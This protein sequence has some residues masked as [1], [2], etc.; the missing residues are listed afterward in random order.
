VRELELS[1][2]LRSAGY[3]TAAFVTTSLLARRLTGLEGFEIY[4]GAQLPLRPGAEA[5]ASALRW[6]D[7]ESRR[8]VFLWVHLYDAHAPYGDADEKQRALPLDAAEY[9]WV[10]SGRF[11]DAS[12]RRERREAYARGVRAA[13]AALGALVQGVRSRLERPFL[14]AVTADHGEALD[15][16]IDA[17]GYGFDHGEFLDAEQIRIPMLLAG[18]GVA[19]GRSPGAVSIRDLH[20][21]LLAAAGFVVESPDARDLRTRAGAPRA[22]VC[23]RRPAGGPGDGPTP[24]TAALVRSHAVAAIDGVAS[25]ILGEDGVVASGADP[26]LLETARAALAE[27]GRSER[28]AP[29]IDAATRDA[30]R[31]LG[32]AP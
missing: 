5:V 31:S 19:A 10:G 22:V 23:E 14:I 21:T 15:E 13:D 17:R 11:A 25:L 28:S 26:A 6:L 8:P 16:R 7:V 27:R 32:Y 4:D 9:G 18:A 2:R 1:A 20:A 12:V 24:A 29:E 3:A 30:L